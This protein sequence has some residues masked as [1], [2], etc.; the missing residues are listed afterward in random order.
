MGEGERERERERGRGGGGGGGGE[1]ERE[2]ERGERVATFRRY[3]FLYDG[4]R[5]SVEIETVAPRR[6]S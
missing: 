6:C 4:W 1:R 2:R 5:Q 3:A